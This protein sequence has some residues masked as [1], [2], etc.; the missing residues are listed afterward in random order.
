MSTLR[1]TS[2]TYRSWQGT[3]NGLTAQGLGAALALAIGVLGYGQTE[4]GDFRRSS[5]VSPYY[6]NGWGLNPQNHRYQPESHSQ[7]NSTNVSK[8]KLKWVH[9]L[10]TYAPRS[11]PLVSNDAVYIGDGARGLVALDRETGQTL[12]TTAPLEHPV[13]TSVSYHTSGERTVLVFA[14]NQGGVRAVDASDGKQVWHTIVD[15]EPT[16]GYTGSP[17]IY[18]DSVYVPLSTWEIGLGLM[19]F[20]GCCQT[21][22]GMAALDVHTGD[23]RWLRP[24]ID[25]PARPVGRAILAIRRFAPSGAAVWSAPTYDADRGSLYFGTGQNFSLPASKT[26]DAIFSVDA[27]TGDV[28]WVT[29]LTE[30]D[31]YNLACDISPRH[32]NCPD[33]PGPDVDFGAPPILVQRGGSPDILLAGQ[34]SS[35]VFALDPN[36]GSVL[37]SSNLGRGGLLGGVH[38]GMAVNVDLGL[39]Y[40]PISDIGTDLVR[41]R[42]PAS[43]GLHA[44]NIDSGDVAW[45][46][47]REPE[48]AERHCWPGISAAVTATNDIVF[49]AGMDGVLLAY[50]AESGEL[51]WSYDAIREYDTVNGETANGGCFDSHGIMVAGSMVLVSSGYGNFG[52][53]GGNAFLVFELS[54]E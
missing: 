13:S 38:F 17:L 35:D 51:L 31:A 4:T 21:S 22:G 37:W 26:S 1:S 2:R 25:E 52:Q 24:T 34:K 42:L 50:H 43:P 45:S 40:V 16:T 41:L 7:V 28:R 46:A 49:A 36:D 32:P 23:L 8:L 54:D 30:N 3:S 12:W 9:G 33:P 19:P 15:F 29:Q 10:S 47:T 18:G 39:L 44:V 27:S 11:Y 48:C 6:S 5:S 20:F 53:R 14:T